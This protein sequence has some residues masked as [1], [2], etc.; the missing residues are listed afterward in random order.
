MT[1][2]DRALEGGSSRAEE[3]RMRRVREE[4]VV[5]RAPREPLR[6]ARRSRR[7]RRR[8]DLPLPGQPGAEVRLP[9]LPVLRLGPRLLSATLV[10]LG[11]WLLVL[12]FT[13]PTFRVAE[14]LVSG[15]RILSDGQLRSI[16]QVDGQSV[17]LVDPET[18]VERL[19]AYPEVAAAESQ[20]RWPNRVQVTV[21]ERQPMARWVDGD[22]TWWISPEGIAYAPHGEWPGVVEIVSREPV[23]A[24]SV[25][26]LAP[27]ISIDVL[28]AAA[29]LN[30]LLPQAAP[31][32]Y[33]PVHGLGFDDQAGWTAYF[34]MAGDMVVKV[35]MYQALAA[36]LVAHNVQPALVSVEDV[37]APYYRMES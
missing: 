20:V 11:A 36:Y 25:D 14:A 23:L 16:A 2:T 15:N 24:V 26:P 6:K 7:P 4:R 5:E 28:E 9:A 22:R 8:Y 21:V 3:V 32:R 34:G 27:V 31:L 10:G 12:L 18:V 19:L 29:V 17:F 1:L 13:A 35:R 33:D 30:A 37:A